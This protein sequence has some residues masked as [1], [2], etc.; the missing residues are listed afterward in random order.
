MIK[1]IVY[2]DH[3][4]IH[5]RVKIVKFTHLNTPGSKMADDDADR[6]QTARWLATIQNGDYITEIVIA[7]TKKFQ[8]LL[9]VVWRRLRHWFLRSPRPERIRWLKPSKSNQVDAA[10]YICAKVP[11]CMGATIWIKRQN[12]LCLPFTYASITKLIVHVHVPQNAVYEVARI[13][14]LQE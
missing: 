11:T 13:F 4:A 6:W 8:V 3:L 10:V 5:L 1:H 7:A 2:F 12:L 9:R 14:L